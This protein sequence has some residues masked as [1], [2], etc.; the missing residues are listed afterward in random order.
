MN[1][2]GLVDGQAEPLTARETEVLRLMAA[3][4]SSRG[5]AAQLGISYATVRSHIRSMGAKLG[6]HSKIEAVVKG[7]E[8][9]LIA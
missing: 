9:H 7:R 6:V 8:L 2:Y 1:H 4:L 5:I 3:G